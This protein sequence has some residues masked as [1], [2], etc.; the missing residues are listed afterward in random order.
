MDMAVSPKDVKV[1]R[2]RVVG[3][4]RW[5]MKTHPDE[6]PSQEALATKM[7]LTGAAVSLLLKAGS[8]RTPDFPTLM[9]IKD[10]THLGYDALLLTDPPKA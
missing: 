1:A 5:Y 3:W 8:D 7:G 10:V 2:D 9:A 6:I 4:L